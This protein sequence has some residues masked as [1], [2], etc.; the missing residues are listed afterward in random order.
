[1]T[2][3]ESQAS[4]WKGLSRKDRTADEDDD[5]AEQKRFKPTDKEPRGIEKKMILIPK[6]R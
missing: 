4:G 6:R 5:Q 2:S 3:E 1:M